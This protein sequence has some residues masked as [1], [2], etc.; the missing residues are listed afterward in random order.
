MT[1]F[2]VLS[3]FASFKLSGFTDKRNTAVSTS[4]FISVQSNLT[5][6][7]LSSQIIRQKIVRVSISVCPTYDAF[8]RSDFQEIMGRHQLVFKVKIACIKMFLEAD[9][10]FGIRTFSCGGESGGV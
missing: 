8:Q 4:L 6:L 5:L 7:S 9:L 10:S 3:S 1:L 2:E